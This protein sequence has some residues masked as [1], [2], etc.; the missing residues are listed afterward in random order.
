MLSLIH[1]YVYSRA[2]DLLGRHPSYGFV[3]GAVSGTGGALA[4][5]ETTKVLLGIGSALLGIV[6]ACYTIRI[7]RNTLK[8][9]ER[10]LDRQD[11]QANK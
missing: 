4:I 2:T 10:I 1:S 3:F 11:R 7:Q 8:R 5:F 9:Q 6:V